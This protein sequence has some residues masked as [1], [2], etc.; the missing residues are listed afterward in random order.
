MYSDRY[1]PGAEGDRYLPA[2]RYPPP[3]ARHR[4]EDE[5]RYDAARYRPEERRYEDGRYRP[6]E[7]KRHESRPHHKEERPK[8]EANSKPEKQEPKEEKP[9]RGE[10]K[11]KKEVRKEEKER[12]GPPPAKREE[13]EKREREK[14]PSPVRLPPPPFYPALDG[15]PVPPP[16]KYVD[17]AFF[18]LTIFRSYTE[19]YAWLDGF[20]KYWE[21]TGNVPY[22]PIGRM[23]SY[24]R[25]LGPSRS[26]LCLK[27]LPDDI[28]TRV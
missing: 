4:P 26:T 14:R 8:P 25:T 6:E 22:D 7:E 1:L 13:R 19:P 24:K 10:A 23:E 18:G 15:R 28:T 11:P 5:R 16:P 17:F 2:D 9:R 3:E 21:T 20:L 27:S 12:A